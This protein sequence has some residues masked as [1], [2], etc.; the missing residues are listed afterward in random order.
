MCIRDR[1]I[2]CSTNT[3]LHLPAIAHEVGIRITPD[4]FEEKG[5][6]VPV[7]CSLAPG[8]ADH[9]VDLYEAGGVQALMKEGIAVSYTHLDVYKRQGWM[10]SPWTVRANI[11]RR[12][13]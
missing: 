6:K 12:R 8:G 13:S 2:G 11:P 4:D 10:R 7:V 3:L 9:I 1:L 5:S